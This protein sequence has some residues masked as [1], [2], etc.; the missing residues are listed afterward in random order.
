M[1]QGLQIEQSLAFL[2]Y[3][4]SSSVKSACIPVSSLKSLPERLVSVK[5]YVAEIMVTSSFG[6]DNFTSNYNHTTYFVKVG[7]S[8]PAFPSFKSNR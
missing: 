6:K 1:K 4:I 7:M 5:G 2:N 8:D 3:D